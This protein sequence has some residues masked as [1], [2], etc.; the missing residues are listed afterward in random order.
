M[1]T[2]TNE[3]W[4]FV[5][6]KPLVGVHTHIAQAVVL[7]LQV[8]DDVVQVTERPFGGGGS[9]EVVTL[10]GRG[11]PIFFTVGNSS[12]PDITPPIVQTKPATGPDHC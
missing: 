4:H 1:P 6:Q 7:V 5:P 8:S 2:P 11:V 3:L 10:E 9:S 12:Y